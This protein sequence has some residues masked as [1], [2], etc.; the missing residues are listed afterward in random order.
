MIKI[1]SPSLDRVAC[2][3][4]REKAARVQTLIAKLPVEALD[5]PVL[6]RLSWTNEMDLHAIDVC[7]MLE[8]TRRKLAAVVDGQDFWRASLEAQSLQCCHHVLGSQPIVHVDRERLPAQ[9]IDQS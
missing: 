5:V 9:L 4:E 2:V 1:R 7:P 6:R 8:R 3:S